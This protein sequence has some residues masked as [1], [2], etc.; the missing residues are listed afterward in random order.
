MKSQIKK[1]QLPNSIIV[2]ALL[3][4]FMVY[5]AAATLL[6]KYAA[7]VGLITFAAIACY[8]SSLAMQGKKR[9]VVSLLIIWLGFFLSIIILAKTASLTGFFLIIAASV[10]FSTCRITGWN[11][12]IRCL[13]KIGIIGFFLLTGAASLLLAHYEK[14]NQLINSLQL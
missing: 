14:T 2:M 3:P 6:V 9:Q 10:V 13:I 5:I 11:R 1:E 4:L 7:E 12:K 8:A